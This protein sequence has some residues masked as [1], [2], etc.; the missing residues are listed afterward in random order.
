MIKMIPDILTS[1][2]LSFFLSDIDE[3]AL[4]DDACKGG[5]QCINN[6][7][8]YLCLPN[9]AVIYITKE[10]EQVQ[11]ADPAPAV[12]AVPVV[13][14][15]PALPPS[16]PLLPRVYQGGQRVAQPSRTIRCAVGFTADEQ[17]LCRGKI[18][19]TPLFPVLVQLQ[20]NTFKIFWFF[21]SSLISVLLLLHLTRC[22]RMRLNV[23]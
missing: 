13:P 16:Q 18:S 7:G 4:L 11:L 20:D 14:A 8:G 15:V 6:F 23:S 19:C 17:N 3:C 9:S 12:P 5:M 2:V 1:F 22:R 21:L 10:G